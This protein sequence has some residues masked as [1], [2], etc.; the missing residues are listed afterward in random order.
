MA[1]K[2]GVRFPV[3]MGEI[4]PHGCHLVP[5]SIVQAEDYDAATGRRS[6]SIDKVT[7]QRVFSCRVMDMD[8]ELDGRSREMAVKI[9]ADVQPVAP[10]G[11][12]FE[13]V[14]FE[15]LM[16]TP[17]VNDKGRLAFSLRAT[18]IRAAKPGR[19]GSAAT[20]EGKAA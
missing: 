2:N 10:T 4:F 13:L 5:A 17:Y 11:Q 15:H 12:A 19:T 8:R 1:I 16:V 9:L 6:P 3:A 14:E 7:G 18:G 20:T